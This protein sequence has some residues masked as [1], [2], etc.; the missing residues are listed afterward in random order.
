MRHTTVMK[1]FSFAFATASFLAVNQAHAQIAHF[2]YSTET[3]EAKEWVAYGNSIM[4][5][6]CG[7]FC[8]S[9]I[10][11][12]TYYADDAAVENS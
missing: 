3:G 9:L 2:N 1:G 11:Y 10:S 12:S 6:F 7:I 5:G 4:A 8:G